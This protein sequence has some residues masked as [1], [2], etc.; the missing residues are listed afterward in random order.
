MGSL[1]P[2]NSGKHTQ[3]T[4]KTHKKKRLAEKAKQRG[5]RKLGM[6]Q[7]KSQ[8]FKRSVP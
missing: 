3:N 1:K 8:G 5:A 6:E 2:Q 4:H 7:K